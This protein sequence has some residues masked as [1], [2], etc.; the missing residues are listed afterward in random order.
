MLEEVNLF[1]EA[2]VFFNDVVL[3]TWDLEAG[4]WLFIEVEDFFTVGPC[5]SF[6]A[7]NAATLGDGT[8]L[9]VVFVVGDTDFV[10]VVVL[11][12]RD[13]AVVGVFIG[14]VDFFTSGFIVEDAN[15]VE[16]AVV[17]DGDDFV[18]WICVFGTSSVTLFGFVISF[19]ILFD[20][21]FLNELIVGAVVGDLL[22]GSIIWLF[23]SFLL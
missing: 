20:T 23:K 2:A 8:V 16:D 17:G 22:G 4:T 3:V 21:V 1:G 13:L 15:L 11:V 10:D 19:S 12:T 5:A 14:D 6:V 7:E 9:Y 18:I